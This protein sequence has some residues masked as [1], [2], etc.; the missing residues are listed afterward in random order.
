MRGPGGGDQPMPL[1]G[2]PLEGVSRLRQAL[3]SKGEYVGS[4][5]TPAQEPLLAA[6]A[7]GPA[8][9]DRRTVDGQGGFRGNPCAG[10][11]DRR[12]R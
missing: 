6:P 3:A 7:R 1:V 12:G 9:N 4:D 2:I 5:L 8:R 11:A 10:T